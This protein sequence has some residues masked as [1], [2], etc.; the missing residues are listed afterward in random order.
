M[1][2]SKT[3]FSLSLA[4]TLAAGCSRSNPDTVNPDTASNTPTQP[5]PVS[6]GSD[7]TNTKDDIGAGSDVNDTQTGTETPPVTASAGAGT[8]TTPTQAPIEYKTSDDEIFGVLETINDEEIKTAEL[9]KKWAKNKRVKEFAAMMI[10][11]HSAANDRQKSIRKNIDL[12]STD[13]KLSDDVEN[14]HEQKRKTLKEIAKGDPFDKAYIDMQ[15]EAHAAV[16][17][18]L[19]TKLLPHAQM[20]D[21]RSELNAVRSSVESHLNMAKDVQ[22]ALNKPKS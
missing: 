16:L 3:L 8:E 21:L 13:S 19:D 10:K 17:D 14:D 11:D 20:P 7:A 6:A 15:V 9:A 18:F 22:A 4:L 1:Q 5:Q 2:N 12:R